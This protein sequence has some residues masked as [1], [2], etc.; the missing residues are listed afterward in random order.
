[1]VF[2]VKCLNVKNGIHG[3]FVYNTKEEADHAHHVLANGDD[4]ISRIGFTGYAEMVHEDVYGAALSVIE[5][6][7]EKQFATPVMVDVWFSMGGN[8]HEL[9]RDDITI[10]NDQSVTI[11]K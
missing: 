8:P 5:H 11:R 3:L 4:Y 9:Y 1:M 10:V 7:E 6:I 2:G